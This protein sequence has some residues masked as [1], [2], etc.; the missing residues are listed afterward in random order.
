MC[1][2]EKTLFNTYLQ[3]LSWCR[4]SR[5]LGLCVYKTK[6]HLLIGEC[7]TTIVFFLNM[8]TFII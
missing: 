4:A 2:L 7:Y 8:T 6:C 1:Q 3:V 5:Y